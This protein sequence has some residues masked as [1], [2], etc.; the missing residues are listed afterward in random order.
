MTS[1]LEIRQRIASVQNVGQI[2]KAMEMVAAAQMKKAQSKA[3]NAKTYLAEWQKI[4]TNLSIPLKW[5]LPQLFQHNQSEKTAVIIVASDRGLC[6]NYNQHLLKVAVKQLNQYRKED[7]EL[8]LVGK[9]SIFALGHHHFNILE[10]ISPWGGKLHP[11]KIREWGISLVKS[12]MHGKFKELLIIYTSAK[13]PM[14]REVI[15]ETLLPITLPDDQISPP[16]YLLEPDFIEIKEHLI[17]SF[18]T[19]RLQAILNDA[20][21]AELTARTFAMKKAT[22]N[23]E[24]MLIDLTLQRNKIRQA[25]ITR[26]MIEITAGAEGV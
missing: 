22:K 4:L 21:A 6:G 14:I 20:F 11:S 19:A 5:N 3:L 8:I 9:K 1:L 18:I 23:A 16:N 12:F 10:R 7:L 15:T 25:G 26:E 13:N 24:E 17:H 2:T